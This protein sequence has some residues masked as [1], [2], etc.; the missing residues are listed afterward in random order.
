MIGIGGMEM[1]RLTIDEV[2]LREKRIYAENL[3]IVDTHVLSGEFTLEELYC[4]DTDAIKE[5]LRQR[6]FDSEY[7][8]QVAEW[9][10]E[11]KSYKTA[12]EQGLL[13]MLPCHYNDTLYWIVDGTIR[14]VWF[15]GIRCDKGYKP[16]IIARYMGKDFGVSESPIS[17]LENLGVTVFLTR[18]EAEAKLAEMQ[19]G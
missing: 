6:K 7:H 19:K 10:E 4:D 15:K 14:E 12:E 3:K 16:Q 2:I 5:S 11:L 1:E 8:R 17:N 9:L 18:E 13:L